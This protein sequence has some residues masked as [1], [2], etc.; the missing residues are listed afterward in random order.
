MSRLDDLI[1]LIQTTNEVYFITA[2]GR[3]RTAYILVDD[4][5]ELALKTFLQEKT[6][7]QRQNCQSALETARFVTSSNHR[8]ALQRYFEAKS[9]LATLSSDLGRGT[10]GISLIQTELNHFPLVQHWSANDSSKTPHYPEVVRDVKSFFLSGHSIVPMLDAAADRHN[11]RNKFYHDHQHA[12]LTIDDDKCLTALCGMYDLITAL[13]PTF[14]THLQQTKYKIIRCQIGVLRLKLAAHGAQ[15]LKEPYNKALAQFE[16]N[17]QITKW[18]DNFE[19]SI[20]HTIS[21][22]FFVALREQLREAI[23]QKKSRVDK[24][25]QMRNPNATQRAEAEIGQRIVNVLS[26]QLVDIDA[27]MT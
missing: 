24:I 13:F 26:Q 12:G 6:L 20:L 4:I 5:V 19:H 23:A 14:T 8:N 3:V 7:E 10:A 15:D 22:N 17:H 11:V 21:E 2:P 18:S 9:D 1:D 16:R 25:T 27:L